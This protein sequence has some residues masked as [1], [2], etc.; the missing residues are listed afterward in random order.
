LLTLGEKLPET[1]AVPQLLPDDDGAPLAEGALLSVLVALAQP[2]EDALATLLAETAPLGL[3][4]TLDEKL[5]ETDAVPQLLPDAD[6][7][8][9][10]D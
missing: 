2:E 1:D 5:P 3:P 9:L 4:L 7:T 10:A 6:G 8:P